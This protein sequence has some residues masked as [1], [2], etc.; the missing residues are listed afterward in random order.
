MNKKGI[1][2]IELLAVIIIMSL[3]LLFAFPT[4]TGLIGQSQNKKYNY[5]MDLIDKAALVYSEVRKDDLGGTSSNGCIEVNIDYLI[6]N[7]YLSAFDD[8]NITC[9]GIIR[10]KNTSQTASSG[11]NISNSISTYKNITCQNEKEE[12]TYEIN[13]FDSNDTCEKYSPQG[14]LTIYESIKNNPLNATTIKK[15]NITYIKGDD[16]NNYVFYS[17]KLWRITS[18]LKNNYV[19]LLSEDIITTLPYKYGNT[20]IYTWLTNYSGYLKND[21][22]N[23]YLQKTT[24]K[25][26]DSEISS[27]I[28]L[29]TESEINIID[30]KYIKSNTDYMIIATNSIK[31]Y[32]TS[33]NTINED[34]FTGIKIA[35]TINPNIIVSTG[36]GTKESPYRLQKDSGVVQSK[37]KLNTRYSGEY[38]KIDKTLFRIIKQDN[39]GIKIISDTPLLSLRFVHN[40]ITGSKLYKESYNDS[41]ISE[42]LN[43]TWYNNLSSNTKKMIVTSSPWCIDTINSYEDLSLTCKTYTNSTVG[44]MEIG[45]IYSSNTNNDKYDILAINKASENKVA[46]INKNNTYKQVSST[47]LGYIKPTLYLKND[48]Y[49]IKGN[50]TISNPYIVSI[51]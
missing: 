21:T 30:S 16:P 22:N 18:Y 47:F 49:I 26:K 20:D 40:I 46:L 51:D 29:L 5:Y 8:N 7:D 31:T 9:S 6:E 15:D 28:G 25:T 2:L 33:I 38:L 50:G 11:H 3:I 17:G 27:K 34:T 23:T 19:K 24:W 10:I 35:I 14:D 39:N 42:Y 37:T 41:L 12:T 13:E 48:T 32:S 45:E 44:I 4:I 36:N 43:N 1:T